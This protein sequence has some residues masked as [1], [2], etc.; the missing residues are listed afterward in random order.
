MLHL[1]VIRLC[2]ICVPTLTVVFG[3]KSVLQA[4][5]HSRNSASKLTQ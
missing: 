3:E 2:K 4:K 5:Q 1:Q